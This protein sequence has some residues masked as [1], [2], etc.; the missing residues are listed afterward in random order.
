MVPTLQATSGEFYRTA[1][2]SPLPHMTTPVSHNSTCTPLSNGSTEELRRKQ[3]DDFESDDE[4]RREDILFSDPG[5]HFFLVVLQKFILK[6]AK[7]VPRAKH[8]FRRVVA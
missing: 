3:Y 4:L 6:R 5:K 7:K 8:F 2:T 1:A